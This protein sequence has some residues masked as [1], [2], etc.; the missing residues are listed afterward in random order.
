M[1][2]VY[3]N[4]TRR[5]WSIRIAGRVVGHVAAIALAGV[6]LRTSEASRLRCL[7][8]GIR[9]VHAWARGVP[10]PGLPRPADAVRIRYR[11]DRP[12]FR[13]PDGRPV[14]LA[15][16]CWFEA[17][18]SAWC[19][20][21]PGERLGAGGTDMARPDDRKILSSDLAHVSRAGLLDDWAFQRAGRRG[22]GLVLVGTDE[23]GRVRETGAV[24]GFD[25]EAGWAWV[26]GTGLLRLGTP[27]SAI[28]TT[29]VTL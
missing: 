10:V 2:D 26:T 8:L 4:L 21:G 11:V 5:A 28:P 16:A 7:R 27:R 1:A 15:D 12:G 22:D 29:G 17:D 24:Q 18:G 14:A 23:Q 20:A 6:T 9:D 3:R 13:D 25:V 19:L